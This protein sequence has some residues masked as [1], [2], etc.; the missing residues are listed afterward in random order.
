MTVGQLKEALAG[1]DGLLLAS[2]IV[3]CVKA[4]RGTRPYWYMEGAKLKD[5]INQIGMP[6]L[7]YTLSMADL[8]WPDL[9]RLMPDDPFQ[10]GLTDAESFQI[11]MRNIANNPH[12]VSAYLSVKHKC[13]RETILQHLDLMEDTKIADFWFRVEWQAH[14]SGKH[15]LV[16]ASCSSPDNVSLGHIHGFLWLTDALR[17]NDLNWSDPADRDKVKDYFSCFITATNPDPLHAR[18]AHDCLFNNYLPPATQEL[19]DLEDDH[20]N[21]CNRCQKHGAIIAGCR[22]CV[23]LQ[24]HKRG[25]C[26]F[27][28]PYPLTPEPLAFI[29]NTESRTRK[30]FSPSRNDAW[31]NQHSKAILIGWR[32]N[33]DLQPVLDCEAAIKYISKYT[34]KPEMVSDGY[35][36]ALKEVC[37]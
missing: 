16:P 10:Q 29:E 34:S 25:S 22:H 20:C 4:V 6:T 9:H 26:R 14:S 7:F 36:N 17:V 30:R 12:I 1:D 11:R 21:L 19:W 23:P 35:H 32:A 8:S 18:P 31:L 28:F 27:Y 13:L 37:S 15:V 24:C 33:T 2:K 5:M 3:R